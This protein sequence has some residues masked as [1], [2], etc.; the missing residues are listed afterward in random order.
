MTGFNGGSP[1]Q[2]LCLPSGNV[3]PIVQF[4]FADSEYYACLQT[5][6]ENYLIHFK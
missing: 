3:F 6:F 1:H 4:L 2:I 5:I